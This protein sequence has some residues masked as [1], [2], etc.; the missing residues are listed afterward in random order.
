[1]RY[2]GIR[3]EGTTVADEASTV[4]AYRLATGELLRHVRAVGTDQVASVNG[5]VAVRT[6][7][8]TG[9]G[10]GDAPSAG[11]ERAGAA[12]VADG[13]VPVSGD[14]S[15]GTATVGEAE[16]SGAGGELS[17]MLFYSGVR[18]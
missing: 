1:M 7:E 8:G 2:G 11:R 4:A 16:T 14:G 5:V 12:A 6:R 15:I 17:T 9:P 13:G 18:A 10:G 3:N